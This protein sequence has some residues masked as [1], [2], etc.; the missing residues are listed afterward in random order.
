M[1]TD[2]IINRDAL[3]ALRELPSESVNC[4]VTSPP[5]YGL[6][7]YGLDAQIGREDTP[8]QYI[9]RLVEVFRELR[10]VLKDDGTFW[11]NI[12]DTYCGSGMKAGCK[13]KDL[14]GI[15]WLLAFALRSD[16]WYL[17][18]DI[19]WLKENPMPE[20]CRDRP[21]R[22]YEH[23]FLLTKSKKYYYDAAAIAEP[24]APGTA[25]RYRQGRS[26]GHKYAEE[27]PGQGKVQG[28]NQPRSGSY[29]DDALMPTTRNKRDVWLTDSNLNH[30]GIYL[31]SK[32]KIMIHLTFDY[33][34]DEKCTT[35]GQYLKYHRTF[36]GLST[37]ELAEKVGIVPAT[38]VLYEN[39]R[40]PIKHSTAVALANALGI[41]RNRLLDKYTAFVDYPYSS[42]LKKVR[43]DLSLTQ[44]QMAELIGIGQTSYSGWE[45]E[46][47]V[48][49]RKEYDKI[50]AALEKL[51]VNV[52]TYLCQSASI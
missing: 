32:G 20:S 36:Q 4:C 8:E 47:R 5:Y 16:G 7:D 25:A 14:I 9:G 51:R 43:Q 28:I 22:C 27:V 21:S 37:R 48:P 39:D 23:I 11:L 12:A 42:L 6:R 40:H 15:P 19:I 35:P 34:T 30:T 38:L 13:Q 10:R 18:S 2:V 3:Y 24:I 26:A 44:I 52:D 1:K 45:R 41:D 29:Y 17:R 33:K 49:R 46:I 31:Y 50:L